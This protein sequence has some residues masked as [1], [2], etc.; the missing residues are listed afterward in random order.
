MKPLAGVRVIEVAA[1]TLVPAAG[2]VLAEWGADVI[3]IEHPIGGDAQ[4]GLIAAGI[5]PGG[6]GS[7]NYIIEQ[8]N[9]GKRSLG[10]DIGNDDGRDLLLRLCESADVYLTN[11][12]P[13]ARRKLRLDVDDIRA[14]NPKIIYA[15]GSGLGQRGPD[16]E[17]GAFDGTAMWARAGMVDALT[18][19][20]NASPYGPRQTPALG[21]MPGG[22]IIAGAITAA[23]FQ[24]E[25]TGEPAVIDVSLFALGM[26]MMAPLIVAAKLY[27]NDR[28]PYY[29]RDDAPNPI[30]NQYLTKDGRVIHLAMMQ[31]DRYFREFFGAIGRPELGDDE[32]FA[33]STAVNENRR[34]LIR[35]LDELFATRTFAEWRTALA[36]IE[37]IW[38]PAQTV[39]EV[40]Y[41]EQAIA[42]GY[43]AE[44]QG[45]DGTP[46]TLVAN[47]AQFN[48][49][50]IGTVQAA[51][52]HGQH[53][54]EILL[55]LGL[56]W[57]EITKHKETGAIL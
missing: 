12:L 29:S 45:P 49:T 34:E 22:Q 21:D 43:F 46:F 41:D 35:M 52:E 47:P 56:D 8:P 13:H 39:G 55:E 14:A 48:E 24:R 54:E 20:D 4:R 3:K 7:V 15:R 17:R 53:T 5:I 37:G 9:H 36:P 42:N 16:A 11:W 51:P 50:P 19:G 31:Y 44:A 23:L 18:Q 33:S 27:G 38:E 6:P 25:R 10:L 2:A 28:M 57:D 1:W 30:A 26:W 40:N 32:R